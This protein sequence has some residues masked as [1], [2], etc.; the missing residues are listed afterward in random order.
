ML[1]LADWPIRR[2]LN[3]LTTC[4]ALIALVLACLS[5]AIHDVYRIR[6]AKVTQITAL[7]DILGYNATPALEFSDADHAAEVL[8][9]LRM[10]PSI[11]VAVLYDAHGKVIATYPRALPASAPYPKTPRAMTPSFT[12]PF[13]GGGHLAIAQ[14]IRRDT[15]KFGTIY[16][17]S[18]LKEIQSQLAQTVWILLGVMTVALGIS[19]LITG[20][21]H[22]LFTA[23]IRELAKV[24]EYVSAGGDYSLH[25]KKYGRDELGVLC[26]GFNVMLDQI[27][28]ARDQLQHAHDELENR[29]IQRTA[30]LQ[31]ALEAAE[32]ASRAKS[33][34]LANM[35]HEI[36]TPMTAIL[37]FTDILAEEENLSEAGREQIAT[38]HR[39]G[40]HLLRIVNDILDVSK[41]EAGKMTVE[42]IGCSVCQIVAE[43]ASSMRR[44]AADKGLT[45]DVAYGT[46]MPETI[47]TDPTRL[48]QI[49]VNLIGNAIKFTKHGHVHLA[50]SLDESGANDIPQLCFEVSDTGLGMTPEQQEKVFKAFTQADESM[51]RRFGGTGLGLTIC[52]GLTRLLGGDV[53]VESELGK[54]STFRFTIET[55]PLEGVRLLEDCQ[56]A[57]V[58][59]APDYCRRTSQPTV[60]LSARVL[61]CEDGLDNQR[62]I[63]FVLKRAGAQVTLAD[64]GQVGMK[65]ALEAC[66][67]GQPFDLVLMDMQMPILDG[68]SATRRLRGKGYDGPIIALTAHAMAHDRQKCLDAGC[69]DYVSK[70]IQRDALIAV[71]AEYA[72]AKN[73]I[74]CENESGQPEAP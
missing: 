28:V 60:V 36:R 29:V 9:S 47:R 32:A 26:D 74:A 4:G 33:D 48:H 14:P 21:L 30:E 53:S 25:V 8:A 31:I 62:L 13:P 6:A 56:E 19:M 20:R 42:R 3:F 12:G 63:A 1:R 15:E 2:K 71:V 64:N 5:Y 69:D 54:G 35:S 61:L 58:S 72:G 17:R 67:A 27:E 49:L 39:N 41:I 18:N 65:K 52:K 68:Y 37:G 73:K 55:G 66:E 57:M 34:F 40:D 43:I 50:V 46:H 45:L 10:Q 24:M 59:P 23:P 38:I 70:P 7:A 11:E 44:R 22:R 16:L 51:S